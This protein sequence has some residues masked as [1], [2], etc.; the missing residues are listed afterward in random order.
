MILFKFLHSPN[1]QNESDSGGVVGN[2]DNLH[3]FTDITPPIIR[4]VTLTMSSVMKRG[5]I[6]V[7]FV[8][9]SGSVVVIDCSVIFCSFIFACC[10]VIAVHVVT[11]SGIVERYCD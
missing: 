8:S 9:D 6:V 7:H 5:I 11:D 4:I 10:G 2:G 1:A 3:M